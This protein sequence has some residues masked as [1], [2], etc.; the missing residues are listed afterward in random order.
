MHPTVLSL[1][2]KNRPSYLRPSWDGRRAGD[3]PQVAF[4]LV[5]GLFG[6]ARPKLV[7]VRGR[8]TCAM[9]RVEV[10]RRRAD[11]SQSDPVQEKE[12]MIRE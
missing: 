1:R 5:S 7:R 6:F 10:W 2:T 11:V 9:V 3:G 4:V 8:V 12:N